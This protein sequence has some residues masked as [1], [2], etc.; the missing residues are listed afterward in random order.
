MRTSIRTGVGLSRD[1][2]VERREQRAD[3][4]VVGVDDVEHD[5]PGQDRLDDDDPHRELEDHVDDV[6]KG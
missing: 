6:E 4:L 5:Q 2:R 3:E 1:E